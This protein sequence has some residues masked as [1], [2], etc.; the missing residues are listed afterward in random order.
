MDAKK[1][2]H[3]TRSHPPRRRAEN[4]NQ[5]HAAKCRK[6]HYKPADTVIDRRAPLLCIHHPVARIYP[7]KREKHDNGKNRHR[8]GDDI[9]KYGTE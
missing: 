6:F 1:R 7:V 8:P 3:D 5:R 9:K 2:S 4:P